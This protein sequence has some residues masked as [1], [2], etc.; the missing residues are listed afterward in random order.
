VRPGVLLALLLLPATPLVGCRARN[1]APAAARL[2]VLRET[3]DRLHGRLEAAVSR[4][5]VTT[6]AFEDKGQVIVA[7]RSPLIQDVAAGIAA[8]YLQGVTLDL[9]DLEAHAGGE[10]HTKI[11]W[12]NV[13]VGDWRIEV[14]VD[15]LRGVLRSGVPRVRAGGGDRL[16]VSIPVEAQP[17]RGRIGIHFHWDSASV[18]NVVCKDFDLAQDLEGQVQRQRDTLEGAFKIDFQGDILRATPLFPERKLRVKVDLTPASWQTVEAALDAQDTPGRCGL[19][20]KPDKVMT[21]LRA[22]AERGIEIKLPDDLFRTIELPAR[23]VRQ[24]SIGAQ[25]VELEAKSRE[26]RF[27]P[28]MLWAS[29]SMHARPGNPPAP[30]ASPPPPDD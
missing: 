23:M 21:A 29:A 28:G 4:D 30:E 14:V 25:P 12:G 15:R 7:V 1:D 13:K 26:L 27:V 11:L 22:L 5:A 20:M 19:L 18:A 3:H 8:A 16:L 2:Q 24:V 17:A 6:R 9:A 10:L